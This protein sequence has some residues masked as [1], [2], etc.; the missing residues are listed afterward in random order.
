[1]KGLKIYA[2]SGLGNS[3][4]GVGTA[5]A[6]F[7]YW[8]DNTKTVTNTKA[9]NGLLAEINLLFTEL[10]YKPMTDEEVITSLNLIDL[11][12]VCLCAAENY[13]KQDL[14]IAGNIIAHMIKNGAFD[15]SSLDNDERDLNLDNLIQEF[16]TRRL[17]S[18]PEYI[19]PLEDSFLEWFNNSVLS[20]DYCALTESQIEAVKGVGMTVV[21]PDTN[22]TNTDTSGGTYNNAYNG[23]VLDAAESLYKGSPY[24]LYLFMTQDQASKQNT[25]IAR[26]WQGQKKVL[27]YTH[28]GYDQLY[29]SPESVNKVI[30]AGTMAYFKDSPENVIKEL[31][32]TKGRSGVGVITAGAIAIINLIVVLVPAILALIQAIFNF[33]VAIVNV[34]YS[35]EDAEKNAPNNKDWSKLE[36]EIAQKKKEEKKNSLVKWGIIGLVVMLFL[37][38]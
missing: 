2:C 14:E 30:Y 16:N 7:S 5:P 1:M 13:H 12:V 20:Q 25:I 37:K 22:I 29:P 24:Y 11:Y 31:T 8:L 36:E 10:K 19:T 9:V 15:N 3:C 18:D 33:V 34:K 28:K 32:G 38:K 27:D 17:E 4:R 6:E 21:K 35:A 26:K 23:E